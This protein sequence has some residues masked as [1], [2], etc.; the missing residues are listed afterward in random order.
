MV[1]LSQV[2][3][4]SLASIIP[5]ITHILFN[6]ITIWLSV[7]FVKGRATLQGALIFSVVAYFALILLRF[8]PIPALPFV[9]TIVIIE[10]VIKS[11]L[12][13]KLFNTDFRGGVC[14]AGVQM[15]FGFILILPF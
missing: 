3:P 14:M 10:V 5:I 6:T 2:I 4:F 8:I 13:M 12:A 11:L 7:Q 15:L 9:S 1:M